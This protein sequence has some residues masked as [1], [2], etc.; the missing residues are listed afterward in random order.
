MA[1]WFSV[2]FIFPSLCPFYDG[3]KRLELV[4]FVTAKDLT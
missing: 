3:D 4:K 1:G 2:F